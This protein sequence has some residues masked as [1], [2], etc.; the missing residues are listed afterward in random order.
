MRLFA[1][2]VYNEAVLLTTT[3]LQKVMLN[4][5]HFI[6]VVLWLSFQMATVAA[7][8]VTTPITLLGERADVII[9]GNVEHVTTGTASSYM[10]IHLRADHLIHGQVSGVS[11]IAE[12]PE[13][14]ANEHSVDIRQGDDGLNSYWIGKRGMWFLEFT[15]GGY[16]ILP[17]ETGL[18]SPDRLYL[19][20]PTLEY[21]KDTGETLQQ[22]LL[23]Y[24]VQWYE[25][26]SNPTVRDGNFLLD[27][28]QHADRQNLLA[29]IS[30]L[31]CSPSRTHQVI[32]LTAAL[33]L[34]SDDAIAIVTKDLEALRRDPEFGLIMNA[35][36]GYYQPHGEKSI[37]VLQELVK[38][39]TDTIGVDAAAGAALAKIKTKAVLPIMAELLESKDPQAQ[40]RAASFFGLYTMFADANGVLRDS[41][42]AGPYCTAETQRHT[43]R[44]ASS[45]DVA[46]YSRFWTQW[47]QANRD[48]LGF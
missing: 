21:M 42:P 19:P 24:L 46:D 7:Q 40:L 4:R 32:G 20:A 23:G 48:T 43:P 22:Q 16:R 33:R 29:A 11:I 37:G 5:M 41:G 31:T 36:E 38:L 13:S 6:T 3:T 25:L 10:K 1:G 12:V 26:L 34:S 18:C 45:L 28:L 17:M 9:I 39:H 2:A 30:P 8:Q 47:W 15:G 44:R 35:L 27:N 14:F